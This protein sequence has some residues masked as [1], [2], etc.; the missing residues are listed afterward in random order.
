MTEQPAET[1][2]P[3]TDPLAYLDFPIVCGMVHDGVECQNP[4][5]HLA[6]VHDCTKNVAG[7][8]VY[9]REG[10]MTVVCDKFIK[11]IVDENN[12]PSHCGRCKHTFTS[13][14]DRVWDITPL[15][16]LPHEH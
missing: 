15:R 13:L 12:Y 8:W 6:T 3:D 4:A 9:K 7:K 16:N 10:A 11:S 14:L 1:P 2:A 5:T